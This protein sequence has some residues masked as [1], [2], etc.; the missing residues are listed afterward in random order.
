LSNV[1]WTP[2]PS[3]F[4]TNPALLSYTWFSPYSIT[5][6]NLTFGD[7]IAVGYDAAAAGYDVDISSPLLYA[8]ALGAQHAKK[9]VDYAGVATAAAIV[10]PPVIGA[11]GAPMRLSKLGIQWM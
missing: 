1:A 2:T 6:I 11:V 4:D 5:S 3:A 7:A 9:T 10:I 8:F